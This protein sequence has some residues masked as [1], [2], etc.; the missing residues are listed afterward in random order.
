M[1]LRGLAAGLAGLSLTAA[2]AALVGGVFTLLA[3]TGFTLAFGVCVTTGVLAALGEGLA[4]GVFA[5]PGVVTLV[6]AGEVTSEG[7]SSSSTSL[8]SGGVTLLTLAVRIGR[9]EAT[10]GTSTFCQIYIH[11]LDEGE[12]GDV[13][14]FFKYS[15]SQNARNHIRKSP[16][17]IS[18]DYRLKWHYNC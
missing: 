5:L 8:T 1:V 4:A 18:D 17:F 7:S 6:G 15:G 9:V 10:L 12:I 16:T 2:L 3:D 11:R 14:Y 13:H